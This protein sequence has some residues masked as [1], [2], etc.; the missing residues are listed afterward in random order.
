MPA[1]P[2]SPAHASLGGA[3]PL[4]ARVRYLAEHLAAAATAA[5][6]AAADA[7]AADAAKLLP[8]P[9]HQPDRWLAAIATGTTALHTR[10]AALAEQ[11]AAAVADAPADAPA[12][13]SPGYSPPPIPDWRPPDS[14]WYA[15]DGPLR[16]LDRMA[17][18]LTH[19]GDLAGLAATAAHHDITHHD[20]TP[21]TSA[22]PSGPTPATTLT[23]T[24][25]AVAHR[26]HTLAAAAHL[27]VLALEPLHATPHAQAPP[28]PDSAGTVVAA[29]F[30][31]ITT[32]VEDDVLPDKF[33]FPAA[34]QAHVRDAV[35]TDRPGA[36]AW[37]VR[38]CN[39]PSQWPPA[40]AV[41][42]VLAHPEVCGNTLGVPWLL[43]IVANGIAVRRAA[44]R[45]R[46]ARR[47]WTVRTGR[48]DTM[49]RL[50]PDPV[51]GVP[52]RRQFLAFDPRGA[53]QMVE[54][55][56][57]INTATG[58]ALYVPGT[59]TNL[60]MSHVNTDVAENWVA[61][62]GGALA[63]LVFLGGTF[64]QNMW[65]ES[66]DPVFTHAM[67]PRL[68]ACA[69][70]VQV[71]LHR[72][73]RAAGSAQPLPV[74]AIGHSF[75]GAVVGDAETRG[76][77]AD[78]VVYVASP[79]AGPGV[80]SASQWRNSAP[81]VRRYS[82]TA[83]GD[84]IELTQTWA[85]LRYPTG[86]FADVMDGV[87]RLDT[88]FFDSGEPVFGTRGHG[89]VLDRDA[90]AM[91]QVARVVLGAP[92]VPYQRR[93]I[94]ARGTTWWWKNDGHLLALAY[95]QLR[96][97]LSASSRD[98]PIVVDGPGQLVTRQLPKPIQ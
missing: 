35:P 61:I 6:A 54:L 94:A 15:A 37:C 69:W 33:A 23:T 75:G 97:Q 19:V 62:G 44:Q 3:G 95:S 63:C 27:A 1:S 39:R 51:S 7:A 60:D 25:A 78:R 11:L 56:G 28:P 68:V 64:P 81:A 70:D 79:N 66:G 72:I 59:G 53:G 26:A 34:L 92:P 96:G 2:P 83:P 43:R 71:Q 85:G 67:S 93:S 12:T 29:H 45:E 21:H 24:L 82:L 22:T 47:P 73:G 80:R 30:P 5:D 77:Y 76:L 41:Q 38:T 50:R 48:L 49:D 98:D 55:V 88:G 91:W 8:E 31:A 89:G 20:I 13:H 52:T 36:R 84:P 46:M 17:A 90:D 42:A 10:C 18:Q 74:T 40:D 14:P 57:Q 9:W 4:A 86:S 16:T 87:Q 65:V 58:L 32:Y